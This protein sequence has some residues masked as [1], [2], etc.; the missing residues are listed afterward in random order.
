MGIVKSGP[1]PE[2]EG[3]GKGFGRPGKPVGKGKEDTDSEEEGVALAEL[4]G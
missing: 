1:T 2:L 3:D 4:E